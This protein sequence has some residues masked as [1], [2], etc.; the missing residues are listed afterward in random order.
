MANEHEDDLLGIEAESA[1]IA[2][3]AFGYDPGSLARSLAGQSAAAIGES[4]ADRYARI[5]ANLLSDPVATKLDQDMIDRLAS[6]GFDRARLRDVRVHR[7][8]KAGAAAEALGARAFAIGHNDIFFGR[9][10]YDPSTATGR[11]VLA[12]EVA[13]IAP[14]TTVPSGGVPSSYAG[15]APV[16]NERRSGDDDAADEERHEQVAR[17]AE[18]MVYAQEDSGG[19]PAPTVVEPPPQVKDATSPA[20]EVNIYALESKVMG[21]LNKIERTEVERRGKFLKR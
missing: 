15:S 11:A 5:G 6:A 1:A 20:P 4:V 9:G 7:G 21:I 14:P 12:H 13:H 8:L 2:E 18:A 3:D 17:E 19:G 16:L 10:E